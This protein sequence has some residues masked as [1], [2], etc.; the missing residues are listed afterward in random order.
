M[1]EGA[2]RKFRKGDAMQVG[3]PKR[4]FV[5]EPLELPEPLRP[6]VEIPEPDRIP[7]YAPEEEPEKV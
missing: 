5:V 1:V 3:E 7:V 2:R 4:E 6:A